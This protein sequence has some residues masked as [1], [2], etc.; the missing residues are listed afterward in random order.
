[1]SE[2]AVQSFGNLIASQRAR[3]RTR[4]FPNKTSGA[5]AREGEAPADTRGLRIA[6]PGSRAS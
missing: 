4:D 6:S 3:V 2:P 5:A 1:M